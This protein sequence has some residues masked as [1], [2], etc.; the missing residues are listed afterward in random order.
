MV[1][2]VDPR[3]TT[4]SMRLHHMLSV[5]QGQ[6]LTPHV[7]WITPSQCTEDGVFTHR[8]WSDHE[9]RRDWSVKPLRIS[10]LLVRSVVCMIDQPS[11]LMATHTRPYKYTIAGTPVMV[12]L[13]W[14][15]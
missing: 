6:P 12:V 8:M 1:E 4:T 2:V 14:S 10:Y 7:V 13:A 9:H 5:H 11:V 3:S 15:G